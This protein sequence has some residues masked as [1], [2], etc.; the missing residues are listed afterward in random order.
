MELEGPSVESH[1]WL[2]RIAAATAAAAAQSA[3]GVG[4]RRRD[5]PDSADEP[6]MHCLH[7]TLRL[8]AL[9]G[10]PL[11]VV[12]VEMEVLTPGRAAVR[13]KGWERAGQGTDTR[14]VWR[15]TLVT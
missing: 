12:G 6:S 10:R 3:E 1:S 8:S 14:C 2:E 9:V 5:Y 4:R 15:C 7:D 11:V 13:P